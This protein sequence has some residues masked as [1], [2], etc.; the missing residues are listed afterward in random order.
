MGLP[1]PKGKR[2]LDF[3]TPDEIR[4]EVR[5]RIRTLGPA[6]LLLSPAYDLDFTPLEN[7]VAFVEAVDAYGRVGW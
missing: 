6:G 3:G 7:L 1:L 2:N 5:H 4:A